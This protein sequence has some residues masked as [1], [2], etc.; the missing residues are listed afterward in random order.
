MNY[1]YR[2]DD[3]LTSFIEEHCD[4]DTRMVMEE[5]IPY[6]LIH[7][8]LRDRAVFVGALVNTRDEVNVLTE[9]KTRLPYPNPTRNL[10]GCCFDDHPAMERY[11]MLYCEFAISM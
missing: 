11:Q 3:S 9:D 10:P 5:M 1:A 7:F 2:D 8:L 4:E 6:E